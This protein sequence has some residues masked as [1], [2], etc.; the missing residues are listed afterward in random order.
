MIFFRR[1]R[2]LL[3]SGCAPVSWL[4]LSRALT[5]VSVGSLMCVGLICCSS[6]RGERC[7]NGILD[8]QEACDGTDFGG[9][10]CSDFSELSPPNSGSL[11]CTEECRIDSSGCEPCWSYPC[12]PYGTLPGK[13]I[14]DLVLMPANP[15]ALKLAG[16]NR[17]LELSDL[18]P[19][20]RQSPAT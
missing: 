7:G 15:P 20:H 4:R 3:C 6:P 18:Y 12:P 19:L 14:S 11:A 8:S 13:T 9:L 16:S 5:S 10:L 2:A 17:F 1:F